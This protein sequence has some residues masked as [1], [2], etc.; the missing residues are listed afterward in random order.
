MSCLALFI[1]CPVLH[2]KDRLPKAPFVAHVCYH[3][4]SMITLAYCCVSEEQ[5]STS[6]LKQSIPNHYTS[7]PSRQ[8]S[9]TTPPD[10]TS[11]AINSGSGVFVFSSRNSS[12]GGRVIVRRSRDCHF[13]SCEKVY[14][15]ILEA[16]FSRGSMYIFGREMNQATATT[17]RSELRGL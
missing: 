15:N 14:I 7:T 8:H 1:M 11:S 12:S 10:S 4:H 2:G 6:W 13:F 16:F 9:S 5:L 3:I 17:W